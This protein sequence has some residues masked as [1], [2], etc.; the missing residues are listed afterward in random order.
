MKLVLN[1]FGLQ[2]STERFASW[3]T[4]LLSIEFAR[5]RI[6]GHFQSFSI[7]SYSSNIGKY[8]K[9]EENTKE[10]VTDT[11]FPVKRFLKISKVF[12]LLKSKLKY[13]SLRAAAG[14]KVTTLLLSH[15]VVDFSRKYKENCILNEYSWHSYATASLNRCLLVFYSLFVSTAHV[16]SANVVQATRSRFIKLN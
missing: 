1:T 7:H 8:L 16:P 2:I 9:F 10:V 13:K 5:L 4:F 11:R 15:Y 3:Y 14:L 12:D 6:I